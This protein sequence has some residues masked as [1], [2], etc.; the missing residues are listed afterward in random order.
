MDAVYVCYLR[1][2]LSLYGEGL[3]YATAGSSGMDLRAC[4]DE[5]SLTV[6]PGQ[7]ICI[8]SGLCIEV[9]APG[10]AG[11]LYSRSGLG[12]VK[13]L[14]VAQGVGVIDADYRGELMIWLLNTSGSPVS[15][16]RGD[17]VAQLV[18][19]PVCRLH[20]QTV[21]SLSETERGGGGFGHTGR[22]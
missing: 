18:F 11:F 15:I 17:R 21:Q 19:Q 12:A 3:N 1:D 16:R 5:A 13:G 2:A 4:M 14:T 20:P 9:G 8:P 22:S 7:R 6:V 10:V